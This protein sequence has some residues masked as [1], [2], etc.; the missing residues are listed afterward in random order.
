MSIREPVTSRR[1]QVINAQTSD[2]HDDVANLNEELVDKN[3]KESLE[4]IDS[5]RTKLNILKGQ[6][7][8]GDII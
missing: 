7:T 3:S 6:I 8:D 2:I 4:L 5:I 1:I